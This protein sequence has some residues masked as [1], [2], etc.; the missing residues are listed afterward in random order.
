MELA[1]VDIDEGLFSEMKAAQEDGVSSVDVSS[2][3]EVSIEQVN[4]VFS[5]KKWGDYV[6][7]HGSQEKRS[8]E[9][10]NPMRAGYYKALVAS[11]AEENSNLKEQR[12]WLM[13]QVYF[14]KKAVSFLEGRKK[15]LEKGTENLQQL[16]VGAIP[17]IE[18]LEEN[19]GFK[20]L[21]QRVIKK[22]GGL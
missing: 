6:K 16:I 21:S 8:A 17:A 14:L 5:C 18:Q 15:E 22:N 4:N 10:V 12:A 13:E 20:K 11:K 7:I 9:L 3:M 1:H 2:E 19:E